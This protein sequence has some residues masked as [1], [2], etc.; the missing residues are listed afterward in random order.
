MKSVRTHR[1]N[2]INRPIREFFREHD[3]EGLLKMGAPKD[4]YDS[5]ADMILGLM[6][7]NPPQDVEDCF[8]LIWTAFKY[9]FG[10]KEAQAE[11]KLGYLNLSERFLEF[12]EIQE[13]KEIREIKEQ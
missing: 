11:V 2:R 9:Y 1:S 13:T 5:E 7:I 6:A 8:C 3:P 12:L 10:H 4:E